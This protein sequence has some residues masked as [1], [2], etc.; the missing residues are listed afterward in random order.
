MRSTRC[1]GLA[2][3]IV[4]LTVAVATA[5]TVAQEH[6]EQ[7]ANRLR[8][9][10]QAM[11]LY[12]NENKGFFPPELKLTVKYLGSAEKA[13]E[14]QRDVTY[15]VAPG[16]RMSRLKRPA[17]VPVALA[18][19]A[20]GAETLAVLFAD[21]HVQF[22]AAASAAQHADAAMKAR[23]ARLATRPAVN[24]P[25]APAQPPAGDLAQSLAGAWR[26]KVGLHVATYQF[27]P[28]GTFRL[29][30]T[31]AERIGYE[32]GS[33]TATGTW[34]INARTLVMVNHASDTAHTVAGETEQAEI[35]SVSEAELVL[36]T[37]DKRG[38]PEEVTLARSIVFAK[39]KRDNEQIVGTWNTG[40]FTLVLA[41]SGMAVFGP[42]KGEW[43]QQGGKLLLNLP[44]IESRRQQAGP[45]GAPAAGALQQHELTIDLVDDTTLVL[46]GELSAMLVPRQQIHE[47]PLR[48]QTMTLLRV[49]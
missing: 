8:S 34:R 7:T 19:A 35:A 10:G 2:A 3:F 12:A 22:Y 16:T 20:G 41:E 48:P 18:P 43:S 40:Q 33:G 38:K 4:M 42:L 29:T 47:P 14:I 46:T 37:T 9:L 28:D 25:A 17:T 27:N 32:I 30:F 24:Q 36:K 49:K 39:G 45:P 31:P 26:V 21:G 6:P 13:A 23:D 11:Q 15:A 1:N 44:A 5:A